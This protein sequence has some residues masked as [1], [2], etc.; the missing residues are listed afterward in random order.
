MLPR[1]IGHIDAEAFYVSA[2][3]DR[4]PFLR[5]KP[6]GVLGNQCAC[7]IAK[8]Y[9]MKALGIKTGEPIWEARAK[10]PDSVYL[11][12]DFRWYEVPSRRMVDVLTEFSPAVEFYSVDEFFFAAEPA[13]GQS[14]QAMAEALRDR[15][16]RTVGV[17]TTVGIARSKS[18]AKLVSD[19]TKPFGALALTDPDAERFLLASQPVTDITGTA[20][21]RAAR[22]MPLGIRTCL[23]FA[24]AD[25]KRVRKLLIVVG[26]I[27][28]WELNG[29]LVQPL[30]T[31]R[32][33]HKA[34][35][36]GWSL[37]RTTADPN[38]LLA[39]A[40][41][42]LERLIEELEYRAVRPG[43][44][45]VWVSYKDGRSA[46]WGGRLTAPHRSCNAV[47][48][49]RQRRDLKA[50]RNARFS[51]TVSERALMSE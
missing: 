49:I 5:S 27:L 3:R 47:A 18:L 51:A 13:P 8:S 24:N 38:R 16:R 20:A 21:R 45:T 40:V 11:K 36:R 43:R 6:V 7:V 50:A 17:P 4:F 46:A 25:R 10:C 44:L 22:L 29:T 39:R 30:Y 32:P 34:L 28:W 33:P 2:E 48:G 23:D 15:T 31:D 1:L 9:E 37:G 14:P 12:R 19:T 42:S 26:E 35:A 41:R